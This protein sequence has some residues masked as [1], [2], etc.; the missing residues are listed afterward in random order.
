MNAATILKLYL[1]TLAIF[2]VI[3]LIWLGLVARGFYQKHLGGLMAEQVNW[4]AAFLFYLLFVAGVLIF[5]V[6]PALARQSALY[7]VFYGALF[8]LFTYATYDLTNLATLKGWP[9]AI[10][11][12]DIAWGIVLSGSVSGFGYLA[13]RWIGQG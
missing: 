2:L 6:V 7:A 3:D 1:A 10:V 5:A 8:G 4:G 9:A 11:W 13:G 12:V